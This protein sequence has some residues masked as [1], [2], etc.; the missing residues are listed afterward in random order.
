MHV[1]GFSV[2][3]L[4]I[5]D[6]QLRAGIAVAVV[7]IA[8]T[9]FVG[10]RRSLVRW[11]LRV[12]C[13]PLI[14]AFAGA[15]VN[16]HFDYF[17]TLGALLGRTAADQV[18]WHTLRLLIEQ[19]DARALRGGPSFS[20][21]VTGPAASGVPDHGVVVPLSI[22]GSVSHFP[23]RTGQVYLPPAW[24]V[25]P[26]PHLP[27]IELLHGSPGSPADWTRGGGA[28]VAADAYARAHHGFAPIIVMPDVNGGWWHDTECVNGP[29]GNAET[30][31]TVDVRNE[32]VRLFGARPDGASWGIAGLSEGG[33]CALQM[34][35]RHP[36]MFRVIGDFSGDDHPWV[37][38]GLQR[39]FWGTTPPQL[40]R[41]EEA[42]DPRAL[43]SRW[44]GG[45]APAIVFASGQSD[46][47]RAKIAN[48]LAEAR[49]DHIEATLD[50]YPGGHSFW[51]WRHS[52][53]RALP[54][55][56]AR[57]GLPQTSLLATGHHDWIKTVPRIHA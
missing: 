29:R 38:G 51:L 17:P 26:R 2:R 32:V 33:S 7:A 25:S 10:F 48:L 3:N 6:W 43:L 9:S 39:L 36:H 56:T 13:V 11:G 21:H 37:S 54:W 22:P 53:E 34:G 18:S 4:S 16:A 1:I 41:A 28:D 55:I 44:H 57:L 14:A 30:Y 52:F 42:Y 8:A 35:L 47:V 15:T 19:A 31:L 24:F 23:G 27:V 45:G 49:R 20:A 5:V 50:I 40:M 12:A 46:R